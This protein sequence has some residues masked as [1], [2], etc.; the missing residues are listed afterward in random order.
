[1]IAQ[2][3]EKSGFDRDPES[4][5]RGC[6]HLPLTKAR[7]RETNLRRRTLT[8]IGNE[9]IGYTV[10]CNC[11]EANNHPTL[12]PGGRQRHLPGA[13]NQMILR[14]LPVLLALCYSL[15]PAA[16]SITTL[17]LQHRPAAEIVPVIEPLLEPGEK[18][19]SQGFRIFLRASPQ[20]VAEVREVIAN[21]DVAAKTL[22]ITVF[23]GRRSDLEKRDISGSIEVQ[24]GHLGGSLAAGE[25]R[26]SESSGPVHRL[27]VTEGT[28]GFIA[29]GNSSRL[30]TANPVDAASG[31]YVLPRLND[32]R[33]T[34]Q[35]SPF[36]EHAVVPGGSIETL[37]V[38]TSVVGRLGEWLPLGGVSE[39]SE[40]AQGDGVSQRSSTRSRQDGIW[41]RAELVR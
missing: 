16:D 31:F 34:L 20:T 7:H 24:N 8:S 39:H 3:D 15:S 37:R 30:F 11:S 29:T 27:R 25:T 21:I 32:D 41:I 5:A 26:R 22:L 2:I 23:Q 33:V 36:R 4:G 14:Y 35:I 9:L 12:P 38:T 17:Q 1:M 6:D 18:I 10:A 19:T 13:A 40:Q 28:E